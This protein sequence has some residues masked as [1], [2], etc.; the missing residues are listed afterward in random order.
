MASGDAHGD[1]QQ[2]LLRSRMIVTP[3]WHDTSAFKTSAC[4]WN[5]FLTLARNPF[6]NQPQ[7]YQPFFFARMKPKT[8]HFQPSA[9]N[10]AMRF[11]VVPIRKTEDRK[12][13]TEDQGL[14]RLFHPRS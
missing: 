5:R 10:K 4:S 2:L 6:E 3:P 12:P 11:G 14:R 1:I 8:P 13:K 9:P 7:L